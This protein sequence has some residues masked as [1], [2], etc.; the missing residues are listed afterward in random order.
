M[1]NKYTL[2]AT[3]VQIISFS[4]VKRASAMHQVLEKIQIQHGMKR[5]AVLSIQKQHYK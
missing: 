1:E 5:L 4:R 2:G 3:L